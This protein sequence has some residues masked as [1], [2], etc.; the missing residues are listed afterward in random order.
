M[1]AAGFEEEEERDIWFIC[2]ET[3]DNDSR[4]K[5]AAYVTHN[6]S[7]TVARFRQRCSIGLHAVF[8]CSHWTKQR[9]RT[10]RSANSNYKNSVMDVKL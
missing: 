9:R 8:V 10:K 4:W 7:Q 1:Q 2:F 3:V 5:A 6:A